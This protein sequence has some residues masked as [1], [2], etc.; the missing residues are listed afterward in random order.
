M[1]TFG[2]RPVFLSL[3]ASIEGIRLGSENAPMLYFPVSVVN[4]FSENQSRTLVVGQFEK[5]VIVD[6]ERVL[7]RP[8]EIILLG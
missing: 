6:F 1:S 3:C 5:E 2:G 4:D 8:I 7:C